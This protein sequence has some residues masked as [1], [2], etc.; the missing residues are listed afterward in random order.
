MNIL[1]TGG[2]GYVGSIL[3][4]GVL[5]LKH[6]VT[7][8]D[9]FLFKQNSLAHVCYSETLRLLK[10]MLEISRLLKVLEVHKI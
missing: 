3:V 10:G 8:I 5:N 6:K 4:Q 2:A 7:V 9:N 1:I